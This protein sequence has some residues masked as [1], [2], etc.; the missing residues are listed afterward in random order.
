MIKFG[1]KS[2]VLGSAVYY[3]VDKGVWKDSETTRELY[4]ELEKGMS[5]YV[6]EFKKQIPFELP[7]LPSNDRVSYLFKYY[8]NCGV[9]ST[10]QFLINLPTHTTNAITLAYDKISSATSTEPVSSQDGTK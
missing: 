5:P 9:K 2:A 7:P 8:W 3:T 10:F 6:G 4:E 1:I